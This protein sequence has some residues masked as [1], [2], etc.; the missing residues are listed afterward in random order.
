MLNSIW[1]ARWYLSL[2]LMC[3]LILVVVNTP[4]HFLWKYVQPTFNQSGLPINIQKPIGSLWQGRAQ[5]NYVGADSMAFEW[6]LQPLSLLAGQVNLSF[7]LTNEKLR[8][9]G[10]L[11]ASGVYSGNI[12]SLTTN[13]VNGYMDAELL[14]PYLAKERASL[15]GDFEL[16]DLN[17]SIDLDQKQIYSLEGRL[18][19]SGGKAQ[20]PVQR[21]TEE[22][23][24]PMLIAN[25]EMQEDQVV[26][27]V[28][29]I[30]GEPLGQAYLQPDGWGGL[31]VLRRS[32]DIVE[33]EWPDKKADADSIVF[34]VSQ[35]VL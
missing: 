31:R 1:K 13:S 19:Y 28:M 17:L 32:F 6:Q 25:L 30:E 9:N 21:R 2:G 8:L 3:F 10:R 34:E 7:N 27:P 22:L 16:S 35:K 29:T 20:V 23:I 5:L 18:V 26:V 11:N 4:V 33:R 24:I 12:T 14:S 15:T